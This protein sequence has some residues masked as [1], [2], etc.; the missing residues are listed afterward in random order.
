MG[1][2][3]FYDYVGNSI[4]RLVSF[5]IHLVFSFWTGLEVF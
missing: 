2:M 5:F 3:F 4:S 1:V